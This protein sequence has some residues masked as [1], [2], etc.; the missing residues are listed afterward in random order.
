[1]KPKSHFQNPEDGEI[2][3]NNKNIRND[4]MLSTGGGEIGYFSLDKRKGMV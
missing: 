2:E 1:M 3:S 4:R